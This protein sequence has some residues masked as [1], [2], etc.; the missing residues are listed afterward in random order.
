M[1]YATVRY[2]DEDVGVVTWDENRRVAEFEYTPAWCE[3]GIEL[4]PIVLPSGPN[5]RLFLDH[6][7]TKT[8]RGLPGLLA[9]SLPERFG[10]HVLSAWLAEQGQSANDLNPVERLCIIGR[11]G[12]GALTFHPQRKAYPA[13]DDEAIDLQAIQRVARAIEEERKDA[14]GKITADAKALEQ[15]V[16][17]GTSAAGAKAKAIV[18]INRETGAIR[19]GQ[20][21]A[22]KN[23]TQCI[24]KFDEIDSDEHAQTKN[25]G[26]H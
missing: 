26:A 8:F 4:S 14:S 18:A 9:D 13:L 16:H 10:N 3:N 24:V 2:H 11:R 25:L 19:S 17:V 22:P 6:V 20:I 1:N 7:D 23:F 5:T 12:M 15:L 21:D